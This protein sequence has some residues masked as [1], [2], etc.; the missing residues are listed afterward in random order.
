[1]KFQSAKYTI[2][3]GIGILGLCDWKLF[4]AFLTLKRINNT[5]LK[6]KA[7][8]KNSIFSKFRKGNNEI[9]KVASSS[10]SV[11]FSQVCN[12]TENFRE[13]Y[14]KS[15]TRNLNL[16]LTIAIQYSFYS[17]IQQVSHHSSKY[18]NIAG[19]HPNHITLNTCSFSK[20]VWPVSSVGRAYTS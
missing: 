8:D 10:H 3:Y 15:K 20:I 14:V 2:F 9:Q 11:C 19:Y 18:P 5:T 6:I 4:L 7:I 13:S 17:V 12:S 16:P 1:M